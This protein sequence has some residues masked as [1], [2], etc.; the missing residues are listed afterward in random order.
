MSLR[1]RHTSSCSSVVSV[2]SVRHPR[3]AATTDDL[4]RFFVHLIQQ[5][6]V[7]SMMRVA[8]HYE[9]M[10]HLAAMLM[11]TL[12]QTAAIAPPESFAMIRPHRLSR[13]SLAEILRNVV[14]SCV[15]HRTKHAKR[16]LS[17][18][19]SS[20]LTLLC[21]FLVFQLLL[22]I[23][24]KI[25]LISFLEEQT[26][27]LLFSINAVDPYLFASSPSSDDDLRSIT[28]ESF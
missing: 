21:H 14:G 3:L 6:S 28:F 4:K 15:S 24:S 8:S 9:L 18:W 5:C 26:Q 13:K 2:P 20:L 11:G 22:T 19:Y 17:H 23:W 1:R 25:M 12:A 16:L 7:P 10:P 27:Y